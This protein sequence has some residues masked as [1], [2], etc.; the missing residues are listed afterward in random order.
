M[1]AFYSVTGG[2]L[3]P[4]RQTGMMIKIK[5]FQF[6]ATANVNDKIFP[7]SVVKN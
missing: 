5:L 3:P 4:R 1:F 2:V 7:S 6:C